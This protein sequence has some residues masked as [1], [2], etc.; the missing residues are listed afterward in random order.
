MKSDDDEEAPELEKVDREELERTKQQKQKEWLDKVVAEHGGPDQITEKPAAE[1][2]KEEE[3]KEEEEDIDAILS[4][5]KRVREAQAAVTADQIRIMIEE[6][7]EAAEQK[8][9]NG[10]TDFEELD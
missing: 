6:Q 9:P 8:E 5:E 1:E 3:A 10:G 7:A 2:P 4:D